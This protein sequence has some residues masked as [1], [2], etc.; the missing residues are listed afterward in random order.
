MFNTI[1]QYRLVVGAGRYPCTQIVTAV[2]KHVVKIDRS[3]HASRYLAPASNSHGSCSQ[4]PYYCSTEHLPDVVERPQDALVKM[5]AIPNG[6][7]GLTAVLL[8][9]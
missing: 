4:V 7:A 5:L 6:A 1:E 3:G 8:G 2:A 9:A